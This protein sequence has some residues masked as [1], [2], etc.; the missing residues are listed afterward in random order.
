FSLA[1]DIQTLHKAQVSVLRTI[2]RAESAR[3][4][5]L[6][7]PTGMDSDSFKFHLRK[8]IKSGFIKKDD[9]GAYQ[10]TATGK[11]FANNLDRESRTLQK[12]PKLSVMIITSK[13]D[14]DGTKRYLFQKRLRHPF[15]GYWG[16]LSGPV[17]WGE[18][19]EITAARELLKQTGLQGTC[20]V[21]AFFRQLDISE[22]TEQLLEDKL[23]HL[24]T[25]AN[26]QGSLSNTW[27]GGINKWM[28]LVELKEQTNHFPMTATVI[29]MLNKGETY[30]LDSV[31]N[32]PNRY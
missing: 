28:S 25:V 23:F 16:L 2:R 4:S 3:Y 10:L 17:Q 18:R 24:I 15:W 20:E 12:Q 5:D 13:I 29:E 1:M 6:M 21:K 32:A 9:E 31:A 8:L 11:E 19:P 14:N 7:H 30:R 27:Y 22:D 26:V